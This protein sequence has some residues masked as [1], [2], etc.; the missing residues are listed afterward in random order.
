MHYPNIAT[1]GRV[2]GL[3]RSSGHSEYF[4]NNKAISMMMLSYSLAQPQCPGAAFLYTNLSPC[5]SCADEI[6]K[7]ATRVHT[8]KVR[9][10]ECQATPFYVGYTNVYK[11]Y[12]LQTWSQV[13]EN[14]V[15]AGIKV[16]DNIGIQQW[17]TKS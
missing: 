10:R 15:N 3:P 4:L 11:G 13:R 5:S 7:M 8:T 1:A 17:P 16:L 12:K 9:G 14:L 6:K 2:E